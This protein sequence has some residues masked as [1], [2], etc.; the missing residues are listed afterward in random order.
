[1]SQTMNETIGTATM[2]EDGTLVLDLR[3]TGEG[4]LGDARIT[5][6]PNDAHYAQVKQHLGAITAGQTVAVRPFP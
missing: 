5:Y 1:M 3:A 2:L 4:M 6:P